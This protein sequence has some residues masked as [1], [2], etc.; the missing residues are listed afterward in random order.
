M[1]IGVISLIAI[2]GCFTGIE[3]TPTI[4]DKSSVKSTAKTTPEQQL[5]QGVVPQALENWQKGKPFI[6]TPGRLSY[7][8]SPAH[9]ASRLMTGDT[10]RF[11]DVR[12]GTRLAGDT[13]TEVRLITP[14]GEI[15]HTMVESPFRTIKHTALNLPF[16]IDAN[17]VED[18]R[19]VLKNRT[20]W[21]LRTDKQGRRYQRTVITDV[22][23]GTADFPL[24]VVTPADSI[25]MLLNS[26]SASGRIFS[27]LFSLSDP[28]KSYPQ[29]SNRN[30]EL[31]CS[32]NIAPEMTREECRLALG[33]PAEIDRQTTYSGILE[34][35]TYEDGKYLIFTDGILT[36]FRI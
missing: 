4:K 18:V 32:G 3:K 13:V 6:V 35:W 9:V 33:A 10:L 29:I 23:P 20:V 1:A 25:L 27:N 22:L 21:T 8:Y 30:W 11:Q 34:R 28:R 24:L 19:S 14:S 5:L 15:I 16:T 12:T 7:A 31:I 17:L 36:H 26:K 2:P